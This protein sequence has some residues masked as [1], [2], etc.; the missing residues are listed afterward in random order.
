MEGNTPP[1]T[2]AEF[3]TAHPEV[4]LDLRAWVQD[5]RGGTWVQGSTEAGLLAEL[6]AALDSWP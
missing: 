1:A 5:G 4:T 3:A 2:L 6:A